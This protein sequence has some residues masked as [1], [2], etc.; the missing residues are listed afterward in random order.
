MGVLR[1]TARSLPQRRAP[2]LKLDYEVPEFGGIDTTTDP[3]GMDD[4]MS[5][6]CLNVV[7][8]TIKSVGSRKG[9]VKLL[10]SALTNFIGG[11][12]PL[13]Q[14]NGT[15][16]LVYASG[17]N[18]YRYNNA[19]GSTLL[20]GTP[21]TFTNNQQWSFD[22]YQDNVYGG[23]GIDPLMT[24]NGSS[25]A[26][27]NAGISPQ[28]VKIHNNRVYCAN[29]NSSTLYFSDAGNP[30]SFPVNNFI[31]I[32]T[33]DGQVI[34]GLA[35]V[36]NGLLIFKSGSVWLLTGE[37][38]GAGNTTTIGNLQLR[39]AAG[40]LGVGCSAFRTIQR[41]DQV[42]LFMH[43]SGLYYYQNGNIYPLSPQLNTTFKSGMNPGFISLSWGLYSPAEK[44][45]FLGYPSSAATTPDSVILYDLLTKQYALWDHMP[46]SC[47]VSFQF[48][49]LQD[50]ILMGD[51]TKGN[52]YELLQGYADIYGD[53]GMATGSATNT[54]TDTT[55]S[56]ATNALVD[57]RILIIGGPGTG[58]SG[59]ITNNSAVQ[60]TVSSW[61]GAAPGAGSVYTIGW[62]NSYWTTKWFDFSMTGYVKKYKYF[63]LFI[64]A[65]SYP[66]RFGFA[67]DF[68]PLNYQKNLNLT[69]GSLL[70][71][72]AGATWGQS[73][74]SWGSYASEFAQANVAGMGRYIRY[75]F[76]NN[77]AN[78]PWRVLKHST[79]Y[80]LK[81][82]RA[83]I[84]TT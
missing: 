20:T 22:V 21:A 16:Q 80:K 5:P 43:Y 31:Q 50:T 27:A 6:D 54:L 62:Y 35:E 11:L 8:D 59:V 71:G 74:L 41:V 9:Y 63:N 52:I 38:L 2:R 4:T 14:S 77:L 10:T 76:G 49:G 3:V 67:M 18:L 48:S 1:P 29:K 25:Y 55:K 37:P 28:Y 42:V 78:Q 15:R 64:D 46:G 13:Y 34:T 81:K 40:P 83:N 79:T 51:P 82:M 7:Y 23:N 68:H 65:A 30:T 36:P 45:Y 61:S 17:Q 58:S 32:N 60:L 75:I 12:C 73:G 39:Q 44:K 70:W 72:Q 66:I 53:N 26:I 69:S 56:W 84:L 57:A 33:N 47:A 19:G 24:Y